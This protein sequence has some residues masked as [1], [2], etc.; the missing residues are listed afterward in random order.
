M[1]K[2]ASL[3]GAINNDVRSTRDGVPVEIKALVVYVSIC[4]FDIRTLCLITLNDTNHALK[5]A[6]SYKYTGTRW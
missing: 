1:H 3:T 4:I 6:V 2:Y 5:N